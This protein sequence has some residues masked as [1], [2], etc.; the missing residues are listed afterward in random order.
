MDDESKANRDAAILDEL[1]FRTFDLGGLRILGQDVRLHVDP[2]ITVLVGRNGAGKSALL[3][4]LQ[5]G[6]MSA[7]GYQMGEYRNLP[8]DVTAS[9][10]SELSFRTATIEYRCEW[11]GWP[12]G[13]PDGAEPAEV[14]SPY[15]QIVEECKV[16]GSGSY[17]W[18]LED[19]LLT[20][21]DGTT[22]Y[23][24]SGRSLLNW[25]VAR[26]GPFVFNVM[27]YPMHDLFH[28]GRLVR[29]TSPR[30]ELWDRESVLFQYPARTR[31]KS[32]KAN[33]R[34][35]ALAYE[36]AQMFERERT[37]FDEVEEVGRRIGLFQGLEVRLFRDIL[38]EASEQI[39]SVLVDGT[40]I[41][42]TSDGTLRAIELLCALVDPKHKLL[43][44][45][46]PEAGIHPGLLRRLLHELDAFSSD[47]QIIISTHSPQ[48]VDWAPPA[49][50][51]LVERLNGA[52]SVR[53]LSAE[54]IA[55]LAPYLAEEGTLGDFLYGGGVEGQT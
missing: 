55:G 15:P 32:K 5:A 20:R 13:N 3:E 38:N 28:S 21:N 53:S 11:T 52:T 39:A 42:L 50:I 44:I 40:N 47:R 31:R 30:T 29:A 27:V 34:I 18:R 35:E 54:Q 1:R 46:E 22:A 24:P 26:K 17:L 10:A 45:E 4:S 6:L 41:G 36:L 8:P 2:K 49:S 23:L 16:G 25:V 12:E 9:F 33:F 37:L 14:D 7:L 48:V 51:R 43:L 19:G